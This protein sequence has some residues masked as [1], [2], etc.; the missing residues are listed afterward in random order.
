MIKKSYEEINARIRQGKAVV[1][2]AEE[3]IDIAR[4]QGLKA[5]AAKVDVVT[6]GTFGVM[7]SSGAF[8]NFWHTKPKM[9]MQQV[10]LNDVPAYSGIAAV[11]AY[12]GATELMEGDPANAHH[13]GHF[14]YG[15][16]H[17]IEDLIAGRE[18]QLRASSYGTDCYPLKRLEKTLT[19]ADLRDAFIMSPRNSYQNYNVGVNCS[20]KTI[21]TYMGILKPNMGNINFST[22]GQLSP[23]LN[24]PYFRTIGVGTRIFLGGGFGY[25][26]GPG[27]QHD[28]S[29]ER[30]KGGVPTGGAGTLAVTGDMKCMDARFIRGVSMLGY[31]VSLMVGIGVPIP[32]L[33]EEMLEFTCVTDADIL[34]P[35]CDYGLKYPAGE[36]PELGLVTVAELKSGQVEF[37]GKRIPTAPLSSY[38]MAQEIAAALKS[39]ISEG[40]FLL[41]RPAKLLPTA[42]GYERGEE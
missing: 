4:E 39:W 1:V 24:D 5:A 41:S 12:I 42:E 28:P 30:T 31:G 2:T 8:L 14:R 17:V 27:T 23:L 7:C 15:G 37:M 13:P 25:I 20:D 36:P 38:P 21:Y 18:V 33:D 10:W 35:V 40:R 16:G 11:D 9:K 22:A 3:V 34:S 19:I 6:T 32:I 26:S 29:G